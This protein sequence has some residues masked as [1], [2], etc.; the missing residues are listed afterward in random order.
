[1]LIFN[2]INFIFNNK[3]YL[4]KG[5]HVKCFSINI[6]NNLY[7]IFAVYHNKYNNIYL[8]KTFILKNKCLKDF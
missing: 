2:I 8:K 6:I 7:K 3:F 4:L 1:M 5:N